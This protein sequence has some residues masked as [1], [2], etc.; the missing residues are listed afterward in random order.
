MI[1]IVSDFKWYVIPSEISDKIKP[2]TDAVGIAAEDD[3][4][5]IVLW[6]TRGHENSEQIAQHICNL[7]NEAL[8]TKWNKEAYLHAVEKDD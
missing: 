8:E 1:D 2:W 6:L 5:S 3:F 4:D 7:H